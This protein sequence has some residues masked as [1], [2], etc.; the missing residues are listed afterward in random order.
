MRIFDLNYLEDEATDLYLLGHKV[1]GF[2]ICCGR[3]T[4]HLFRTP[5]YTSYQWDGEGQDPNAD[6]LLCLDCS[7]QHTEQMDS[8]W[9][10][11]YSGL[12]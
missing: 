9:A 2:C 11:Y 8:Q 5:S 12:L 3:D 7:I 4:E 1:P 10:D 6:L